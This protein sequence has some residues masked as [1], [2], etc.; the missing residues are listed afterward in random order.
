M[1]IFIIKSNFQIFVRSFKLRNNNENLSQ[2]ILIELKIKLLSFC[3]Q[4][5]YMNKTVKKI[6][7]SFVVLLLND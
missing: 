1:Y 7:K 4:Q 3:T 5:T 2:Y 6:V